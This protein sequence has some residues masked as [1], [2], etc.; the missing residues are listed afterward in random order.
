MLLSTFNTRSGIRIGVPISDAI[1]LIYPNGRGE[2]LRVVEVHFGP[3][4]Q[5][6]GAPGFLMVVPCSLSLAVRRVTVND[7]LK[8]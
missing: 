5:M 3:V 8:S 2:I 4:H 1:L 7:L 6:F